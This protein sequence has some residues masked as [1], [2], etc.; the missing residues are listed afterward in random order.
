[1]CKKADSSRQN[2][3]ELATELC[4]AAVASGST[5][6]VSVVVFKVNA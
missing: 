6:D 3:D 4:A 2:P 5:D 1:M